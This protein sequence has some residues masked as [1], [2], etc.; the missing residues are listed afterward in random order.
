MAEDKVKLT[1]SGVI[2]VEGLTW[3]EKD[4]IRKTLQLPNPLYH[5]LL[6]MGSRAIWT[7]PKEFKYWSNDGETL[8][9]PRG[10]RSRLI[11]W[12]EK[13][14]REVEVVELFIKKKL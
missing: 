5:K 6:R 4:V 13:I 14:G 3:K 1:I 2:R 9:V 8:T 10:V 11:Q 12:L 7:I